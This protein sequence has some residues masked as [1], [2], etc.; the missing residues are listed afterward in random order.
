MTSRTDGTARDVQNVTYRVTQL[1]HGF[2]G[3]IGN[4]AWPFRPPRGLKEAM[5]RLFLDRIDV[6]LIDPDLHTR[7][8]TKTILRN[9]GFYK[10]RTSR[11]LRELRQEID[12]SIPELLISEAELEDGDFCRFVQDL[13]HNDTGTNPFLNVIA[14]TW[15]PT[16]ELVSRVVNSG[17]DDL[18]AKP[19]STGR[20]L[21]RITTLIEARRPF[22]VTSDYIGP[23]RRRSEARVTTIPLIEVP[24]TLRAVA[25]GEGLSAEI[26]DAIDAMIIEVNHQKLERH[27][28]QIGWL[29]DRILEAFEGPTPPRI[30]DEH[31]GR[32]VYVAEDMKRRVAGT[33]F[34]HVASLCVSLAKATQAV[35][36]APRGAHGKQVRLLKPL[37][38][39]VQAGFITGTETAARQIAACVGS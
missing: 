29:V 14:L 20:V 25:T 18:L 2:A 31:L 39:A 19:L 22:V 35:R 16:S 13:R 38:Q 17:A 6:L 32:L 3:R 7:T 15:Q 12:L 28:F 30:A 34:D 4:R 9:A 10:I 1:E 37:A 5:T 26:Q 11:S 8:T 23:D 27:A 36:V 33:R 24:N 21:D